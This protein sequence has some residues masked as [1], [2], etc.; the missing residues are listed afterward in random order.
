MSYDERK[1]G[2]VVDESGAVIGPCIIH[3][4]TRQIAVLRAMTAGDDASAKT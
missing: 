3:R 2:C 1:C 4:P